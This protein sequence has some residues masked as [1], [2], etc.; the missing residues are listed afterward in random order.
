MEHPSR[1]KG[2]RLHF[3]VAQALSAPPGLFFQGLPPSRMKDG[4]NEYE[5]WLLRNWIQILT[6]ILL[7]GQASSLWI[8]DL[9]LAKRG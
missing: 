6:L 9:S 1:T 2:F 4:C 8:L 7:P 5:V 3:S